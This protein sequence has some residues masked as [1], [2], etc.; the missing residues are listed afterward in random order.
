MN[1]LTRSSY[2]VPL[3][4]AQKSWIR[5]AFLEPLSLWAQWHLPPQDSVRRCEI[6]VW[7]QLLFRTPLL[8]EVKASTLEKWCS[9]KSVAT[10]HFS[11]SEKQPTRSPKHSSHLRYIYDTRWMRGE[12][13]RVHACAEHGAVKGIRLFSECEWTSGHRISLKNT[14][15][16]TNCESGLST[17]AI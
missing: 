5:R 1:F 12:P 17:I 3:P 9:S 2:T 6:W 13:D 14:Q 10:T 16:Y 4:L 7:E 11:S 8:L 15:V